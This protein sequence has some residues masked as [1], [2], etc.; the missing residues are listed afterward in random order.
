MSASMMNVR[1][2]HGIAEHIAEVLS[3]DEETAEQM[4][5]EVAASQYDGD[6]YALADDVA[7]GTIRTSEGKER[8]V[9]FFDNMAQRWVE[10]TEVY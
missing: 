9:D 8:V 10:N 4:L 6:L 3:I 5:E 7:K 1:L 2:L